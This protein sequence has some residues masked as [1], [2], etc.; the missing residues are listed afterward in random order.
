[1]RP[2]RIL[3]MNQSPSPAVTRPARYAIEAILAA[4]AL[5]VVAVLA[6]GVRFDHAF[7]QVDL[8]AVAH[9]HEVAA[10]LGTQ[11]M[12]DIADLAASET[13]LGL[14][15]LCAAILAIRR[16][17]HGALALAISVAACQGIVAVIKHVVAR[18]RPPGED[19]MVEAAG[20]SFPSAH[21]ATSV[22]FYGMLALIAE[23][24]LR[25]RVSRNTAIVCAGL[26]CIAVGISRVYLGAHYPTDVLAGWLIG[27][28][29]ALGSWRG[30]LALR[31]R[32]VAA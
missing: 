4:L 16:H 12:H 9:T 6:L 24:E 15:A 32:T 5:V 27:T 22:A 2:R 10:A 11:V 14:T 28:L 31:G 26:L 13:I 17:W 21:S 23:H 19:A 7:T 8:S 30:V 25:G 20:Y 18:D 29:I 1:M 3:P